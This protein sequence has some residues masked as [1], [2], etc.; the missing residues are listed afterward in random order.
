MDEFSREMHQ[1]SVLADY[2][3][4]IVLQRLALQRLNF[5]CCLI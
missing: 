3:H 1:R 2:T 4:F 5:V